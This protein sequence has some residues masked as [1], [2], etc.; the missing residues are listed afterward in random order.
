MTIYSNFQPIDFENVKTYALRERP[1]K[2]TVNDF[3]REIGEND[4]LKDFLD[5]LP[6]ILAVQSLI[7]VARQI[8]RSRELG[9]PINWGIG[10]NVVK[11]GLASVLFDLMK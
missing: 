7:E 10:G 2:V 11:T 9:K 1:S 8:R 5:K 6:A 4:S 3:A